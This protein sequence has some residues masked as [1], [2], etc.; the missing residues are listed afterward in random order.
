M[1]KYEYP[2]DTLS[3]NF[4]NPV[5]GK[6]QDVQFGFDPHTTF[7]HMQGKLSGSI[8][9]GQINVNK[10]VDNQQWFDQNYNSKLK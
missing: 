4:H 10:K 7:Y 9:I 3:T 5:D 8:N 1:D 2:T 6:N